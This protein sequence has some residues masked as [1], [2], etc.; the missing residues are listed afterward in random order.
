MGRMFGFVALLVVVG[1]GLYLY[2]K[3]VAEVTPGGTAPGTTVDVTGVRIDLLAL[4]NAERRYFATTGKYGSLAEL[5]TNG[6]IQ[7][8]HRATY[9]Y[10]AEVRDSGFRII[11]TYSGSDPKAPKHVSIDETMSLQNY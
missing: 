11:A 7:V 8:P 5:Q 6:D 2:S 3:Q 4:A 9:V 10:S 1:V